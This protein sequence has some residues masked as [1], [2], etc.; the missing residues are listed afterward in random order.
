MRALSRFA[1]LHR[2]PQ[3]TPNVALDVLS[4]QSPQKTDTEH[5]IGD[6]NTARK[7]ESNQRLH[8]GKG[9]FELKMFGKPWMPIWTCRSLRRL[10]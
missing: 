5:G 2:G 4:P 9:F 8:F 6:I 1:H 3:G 7:V 10:L